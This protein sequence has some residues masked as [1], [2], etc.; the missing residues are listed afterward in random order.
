M[1]QE[2]ELLKAE[3][4]NHKLSVENQTDKLSA[5]QD[6]IKLLERKILTL[7]EGEDK[8]GELTTRIEKLKD[9]ALNKQVYIEKIKNKSLCEIRKANYNKRRNANYRARRREDIE[10]NNLA[11]DMSE[12]IR[13]LKRN[14]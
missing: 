12:K 1:L 5:L 10:F 3:Y 4:F 2:T 11:N 9:I 14:M 13:V 8:K 6:K 7:I